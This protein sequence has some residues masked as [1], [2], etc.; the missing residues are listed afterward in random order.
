M[1][2]PN[3][4]RPLTRLETVERW[5]SL[6]LLTLAGLPLILILLMVGV[7]VRLMGAVGVVLR[8]VE[9]KVEV[10]DRLTAVEREAAVVATAETL[11]AAAREAEVA[12]VVGAMVPQRATKARRTIATLAET[13]V[14]TETAKEAGD[15]TTSPPG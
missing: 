9:G 12:K 4:P 10:V 7:M 11:M 3:S 8:A 1:K 2:R 13:E 15:K 5:I 14:V 6:A